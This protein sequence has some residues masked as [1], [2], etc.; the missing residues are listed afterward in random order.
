[1]KLKCIFVFNCKYF[2]L[3]NTYFYYVLTTFL[4]IL[5]RI[6]EKQVCFWQKICFLAVFFP[7]FL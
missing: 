3:W 5:Q 7:V 1:M 6:V 2:F 4:Y